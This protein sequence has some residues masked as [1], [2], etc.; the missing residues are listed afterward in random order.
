[1]CAGRLSGVGN[2]VVVVAWCPLCVVAVV[3]V[4]LCLAVG[5]CRAVV[6]FVLCVSC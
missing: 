6:S 3:G 1:M 4:V 5:V 2:D